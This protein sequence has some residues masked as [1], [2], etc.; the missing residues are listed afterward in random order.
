MIP[1]AGLVSCSAHRLPDRSLSGGRPVIKMSALSKPH[2]FR[3]N[4]RY[5]LPEPS[6]AVSRYHSRSRTP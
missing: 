2:H 5:E 3:Y 1:A 4:V 6:Y